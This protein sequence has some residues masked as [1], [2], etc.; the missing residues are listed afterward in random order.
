M[1]EPHF[2]LPQEEYIVPDVLQPGL[3]LVFCGTAPSKTSAAA[4]A[5]YANPQNKFWRVLHQVGLIPRKMKPQE[6]PELPQ[7]GIGLTDVC[8]RH[9]G[10][11]SVLPAEG[12]TPDEL[13][14]KIQTYRP[15]V[16]A[17]TSKRAAQEGLQKKKLN[18]GLQPEKFEGAEVFVLPST[19]PLADSHFNIEHWQAL[20]DHIRQLD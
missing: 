17:F 9:S 6:F 18:F 20:S 7:Y 1:T 15:R 5:Y 3:K 11:D 12:F 19:S 16:I 14:T 13:Q 8:K 2:D 10:I 4:K